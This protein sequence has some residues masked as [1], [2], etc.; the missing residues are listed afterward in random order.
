MSDQNDAPDALP[1]HLNPLGQEITTQ[2]AQRLRLVLYATLLLGA[3]VLAGLWL[4][5]DTPRSARA[6]VEALQA[7]LAEKDSRIGALQQ[8]ARAPDPNAGAGHLRPQD[9]AR[10]NREGR[11]YI[12]ALKR[13]GAQGAAHLVEWFIGRWDALL[14]NPQPEDRTGRRAATLALLVGGMAA[15]LN[16][17]DYV[18]WQAEFLSN[19]WLG[20]LHIDIDGDG[21][22]GPR[23]GPNPH[24]GFAN[25]SV[26]HVAM[27][28]NQ[29]MVDGQ[30]LMMPEMRCDRA[31]SR[32]SV[33]LQGDTL[34]DAMSEFV[35][36]VREQGF[37]VVEKQE[38]NQRLVLVGNKPEKKNKDEDL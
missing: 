22:P 20:E 11:A 10:H 27:A 7:A 3:G 24:D 23:S 31:E 29:A 30:I 17:G 18:P 25:V 4:A 26:C 16:P 8:L 1:P 6:Q 9:R 37:L 21:L 2:A 12:N 35:R 28:L 33:F 19:L 15:N 36:A 5:P 38:N 14:D 13:T 32:M 34:N